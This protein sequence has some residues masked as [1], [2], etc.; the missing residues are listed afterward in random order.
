MADEEDDYCESEEIIEEYLNDKIFRI[1][2]L[3][4]LRMTYNYLRQ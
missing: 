1:Y 4:C 3:G 2:F